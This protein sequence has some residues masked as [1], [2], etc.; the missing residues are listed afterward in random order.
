[1]RRTVSSALVL[2]FFTG[3]AIAQEPTSPP[4]RDQALALVR[5][6]A[7]AQ[8]AYEGIPGMSIAIV[9]DQDLVWSGGFGAADPSA[10]RP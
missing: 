10:G 9:R 3:I 4:T 6:W 5:A 1:M 2:L 7:D 8:R